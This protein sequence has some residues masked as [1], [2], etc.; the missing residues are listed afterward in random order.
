MSQGTAALGRLHCHLCPRNGRETGAWKAVW[1]TQ[2]DSEN[3]LGSREKEPALQ[4]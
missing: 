4:K 1:F 3:H 2:Q